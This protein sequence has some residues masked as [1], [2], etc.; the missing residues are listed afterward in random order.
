MLQRQNTWIKLISTTQKIP[1]GHETAKLVKLKIIFITCNLKWSGN[2]RSLHQKPQIFSRQQ[3][4]Y[5]TCP[6]R[7]KNEYYTKQSKYVFVYLLQCPANGLPSSYLNFSIVSQVEL[8]SGL[9]ILN[10]FQE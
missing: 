10:H 4:I 7:L 6:F 8:T 2:P 3:V 5:C 1:F 9:I